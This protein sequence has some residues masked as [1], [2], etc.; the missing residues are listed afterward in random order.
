[1]TDKVGMRSWKYELTSDSIN[2]LFILYLSRNS[3]VK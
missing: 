1:M 2:S 3:V